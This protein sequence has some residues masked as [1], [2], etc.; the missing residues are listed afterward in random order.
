[1][2]HCHC[3]SLLTV[4]EKLYS[5]RVTKS[6]ICETSHRRKLQK[7]VAVL[8]PICLLYFPK[9][10]VDELCWVKISHYYIGNQQF[11]PIPKSTFPVKTIFIWWD[12]SLASF[13]CPLVSDKSPTLFY[14]IMN[15]CIHASAFGQSLKVHQLINANKNVGKGYHPIPTISSIQVPI[16]V[17][18][19]KEQWGLTWILNCFSH[20]Y[21]PTKCP[22]TFIL[23]HEYK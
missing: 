7:M 10:R 9:D 3:L 13:V 11:S 16:Q 21:D 22:I 15:I 8:C 12:S 5:V 4:L 14:S 19:L 1:M 17:D 6:S 23:L 18:M 20:K 2:F